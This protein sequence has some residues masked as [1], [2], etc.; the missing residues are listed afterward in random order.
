MET[1]KLGDSG[2]LSNQKTSICESADLITTCSARRW[3]NAPTPAYREIAVRRGGR[4]GLFG[5]VATRPVVTAPDTAGRI[6]AI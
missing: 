1:L 6:V 2:L 4:L 3:P 5:G